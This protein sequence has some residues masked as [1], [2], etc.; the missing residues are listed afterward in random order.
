MSGQLDKV[1]NSYSIH[2]THITTNAITICWRQLQLKEPHIHPL[3]WLHL[4]PPQKKL[5]KHVII[6]VGY[7]VPRMSTTITQIKWDLWHKID[8]DL[9]KESLPQLDYSPPPR[10]LES[11]TVE[12]WRLLDRYLWQ[13]VLHDIWWERKKE[14]SNTNL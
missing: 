4:S 5:F 9:Q 2:L 8:K 14:P 12:T 6:F 1:N 11:K 3:S 7:W 13:I 10:C